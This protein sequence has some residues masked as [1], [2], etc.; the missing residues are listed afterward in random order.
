MP[1]LKPY[2]GEFFLWQYVPSKPA[3]LAIAALFIASTLLV[4]F[5]MVK[6]RTL[7]SIPFVLGGLLEILGFLARAL[8]EDN[9]DKLLPYAIQNI[10]ILVAPALFAASI[11]MTLGRLMRSVRGEA[12]SI[13]PVRWLTRLFVLG[14]IFSFVV[15][16]FGG[17]LATNEKVD[18]KLA[19]N[20][21]IAGLAIQLV[22]FGLFAVTTIIFH[23]RMRRRPE[24]VD[25]AA[26][27]LWKTTMAMMYGVSVLVMVRSV[28]RVIE[29][30][31]GGNG[32]LLQ[33]E[34][35]LY[36]FDAALMFITMVLY[37]WYYPGNLRIKKGGIIVGTE[38]GTGD[39]NAVG[40]R[41]GTSSGHEMKNHPH[42]ASEQPTAPLP[43]MNPQAHD[44]R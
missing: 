20:V 19:E 15:Q 7:F 1:E 2:K 30:T 24:G 14:D 10:F 5:R 16:I 33:H 18:I 12:L 31:V 40:S 34:W 21:I 9:T 43:S 3:A 39:W 27:P 41:P 29:Y 4:V 13:I 35:P 42:H 6:T 38:T 25:P 28:F 22:I 26:N 11:Y 8:A 32:Y 44:Y 36:V 37:G 17:G 23:V